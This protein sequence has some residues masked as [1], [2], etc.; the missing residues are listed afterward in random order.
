MK[1][2]TKDNLIYLGVAGAV[3]VALI[4]YVFY[5]DRTLGRIPDISGPILWGFLSTPVL[6]ALV[7][8]RF[9][10]YCRRRSLWII[11]V[12]AAS[13]NM[14]LMFMAHCFRWDPPVIVCSA[15]TVVWVTVALV[16]AGKF[17]ARSG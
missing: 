3:A 6:V 11:T 16:V 7:L 15:M 12:V 9:W 17:V 10:E 13:T 5:T 2:K 1:Q 4:F 14:S 8:E